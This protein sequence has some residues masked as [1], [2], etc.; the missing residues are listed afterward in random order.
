MRNRPP[1]LRRLEMNPC[2]RPGVM[3]GYYPIPET[4]TRMHSLPTQETRPG[5]YAQ[6]EATILTFFSC[7]LYPYSWPGYLLIAAFNEDS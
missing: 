7:P 6:L 3:K 2:R 5:T 1:V 4:R